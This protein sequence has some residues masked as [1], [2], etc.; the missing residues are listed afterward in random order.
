LGPE[1]ETDYSTASKQYYP[2]TFSSIP[3]QEYFQSLRAGL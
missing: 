3:K 2:E 1:P